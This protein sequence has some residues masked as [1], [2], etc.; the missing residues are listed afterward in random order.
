MC[1]AKPF[2]PSGP[3]CPRPHPRSL[4]VWKRFSRA[5]VPPST[6]LPNS[7]SLQQ[8]VRAEVSKRFARSPDTRV[9][10]AGRVPHRRIWHR[11]LGRSRDVLRQAQH[12]RDRAKS[13]STQRERVFRTAFGPCASTGS[14]RTG[15]GKKRLDTSARTALSDGFRATRFDGLSTN[16]IGQRA[17]RYLSANGSPR[18][19]RAESRSA[20]PPPTPPRRVTLSAPSNDPFALS[21]SKRSPPHPFALRYRSALRSP[22]LERWHPHQRKAHRAHHPARAACTA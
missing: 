13:A 15:W 12:E 7:P 10:R 22:P 8:P 19:V 21:L 4:S 5:P 2:G 9:R 17:L 20:L 16:G 1:Q 11:P 14:A 6:P 3:R 18:T